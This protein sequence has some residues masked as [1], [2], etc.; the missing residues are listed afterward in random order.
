MSKKVYISGKISGEPREAVWLKFREAEK[1][2]LRRGDTPVSPLDNGLPPDAPW[3]QHMRADITLLLTCDEVLALPDWRYSP[4]ATIEI[5]LAEN[6]QNPV[7]H[8]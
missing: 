6:L 4:G 2:I 5:R 3:Q 7:T 1:T 8:L